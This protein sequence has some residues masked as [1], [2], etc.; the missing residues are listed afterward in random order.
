M[1]RFRRPRPAG[2]VAGASGGRTR[3]DR[4]P[5]AG[6]TGE[7]GIVIDGL[8]SGRST[9]RRMDKADDEYR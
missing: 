5:G 9:A 6:R 1:D 2:A 4:R 3:A 8:D 7:V